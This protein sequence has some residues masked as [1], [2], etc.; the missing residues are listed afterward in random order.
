MK[1]LKPIIVAVAVVVSTAALA[2]P[3]PPAP[4]TPPEVPQPPQDAVPEAARAEE[5]EAAR[6]KLAGARAELE[7]A[8]QE[9]A[10]LSAERIRPLADSFYLNQ[11]FVRFARPRLGLNISN[12]DD[13]VRVIGV[14]P[15]GPGATAGIEIGDLIVAIGS[16]DVDASAGG[17]STQVFLDALDDVDPG[18]EVELSLLRDGEPRTI[19]VRT[20]DD[21]GPVWIGE[22]GER[23]NLES[24]R[25]AHNVP[26]GANRSVARVMSQPLLFGAWSDMQLVE[27]T[28]QLGE[29]FGTDTG[30]LVVRAPQ[31]AEIDLRDGDV[32]LQIGARTPQSVGHAM[33]ILGSFE[34]DEPLELTIMRDQRRQSIALSR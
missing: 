15:G 21:D 11:Q 16:T 30:L 24:A 27:L 31:D 12:D 18:T 6:E 8:A 10:R 14:T 2:Q 1:S 17:N 7:R 4:P 3:A 20:S 13:G 29:Y 9:L 5:L 32:I 26:W 23:I 33:R 22:L 28:P 25:R 19:S 34:P